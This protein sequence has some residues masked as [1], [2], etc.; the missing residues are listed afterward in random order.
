MAKAIIYDK[1]GT[2][3]DFDAFWVP[4]ARAAI[5]KIVKRATGA[6]V[7]AAARI[8]AKT[9]REIGISGGST[10]PKG[11]L[12]GGTYSQFAAT[13]T[14]NLNEGGFPLRIDRQEVEKAVADN[15]GKGEILSVCED[16]RER[17]EE[18]R[19]K[20]VLFVV[21][22]DDRAITEYCLEKL[23]IADLFEKIYCDDGITPHKP[24]PFAAEEIAGT[25]KAGKQDIFMIGD[26]ATDKKFAD[27]A[28]IRFAYVG[29]D[30][31]IGEKSA[32]KAI[33]AGKATELILDLI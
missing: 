8:S 28:G 14:K 17:L 25:L 15:A 31:D 11:I 22:T 29:K 4:V 16:L 26:T 18:A 1:D 19:K 23:G 12:C 13:L 9:E 3:M 30:P 33:N 6:D 5:E 20:A 27:G 10:D 24:D 32:Y 7:S 21:T 2:L